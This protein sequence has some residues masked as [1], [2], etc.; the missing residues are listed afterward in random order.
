MNARQ[1]G[2]NQEFWKK[3]LLFFHNL[4]IYKKTGHKILYNV[5]AIIILTL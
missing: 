4:M 5:I 2:Q 3:K 1:K